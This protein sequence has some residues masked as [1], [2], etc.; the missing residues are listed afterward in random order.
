MCEKLEDKHNLFFV[1]ADELI[2]CPRK[3]A[4]TSI[5]LLNLQPDDFLEDK[6]SNTHTKI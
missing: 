3:V 4:G 1:V 6:E 5:A 2:F